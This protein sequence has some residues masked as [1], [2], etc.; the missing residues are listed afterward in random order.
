MGW[1]QIINTPSNI[2]RKMLNSPRDIASIIMMFFEHFRQIF[3]IFQLAVHV[4][5]VCLFSMVHR[6]YIY[7]SFWYVIYAY[8]FHFEKNMEPHSLI[9]CK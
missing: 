8:C 9:L 4:Y 6:N 1:I 5:T 7:I 3:Y 2:V